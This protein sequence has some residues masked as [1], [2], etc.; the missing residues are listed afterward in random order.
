M[1]KKYKLLLLLLLLT[2]R[3]TWHLVTK[4]QGHVTHTENDDVFG[5]QRK[6]QE[7]Q[8]HQY[9]VANK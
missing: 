1:P 2:K 6:K 8:R 9:E 3:L 7:G 5:R 4:L